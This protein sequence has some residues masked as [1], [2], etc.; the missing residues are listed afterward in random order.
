MK[1]VDRGAFALSAAL[2]AV[3]GFVDAVGFLDTGGLFVSFMSGNSTQGAVGLFD[4]GVAVA[5]VSAGIIAAFVLGVTAG[6]V[7]SM[8]A[9]RPRARV[10][11]GAAAAVAVT[12][13][14]ALAG[15]ATLWRAG[16]LAAAMGALNTLFLA[17]GR[18]R[19]AITYA[20][21]TLVSL[22]LGLASLVTGRSRTAWR[23]PLLLWASLVGGAVIGG[24]AHRLGS[25]AALALAALALVGASIVIAVRG[26]SSGVNPR[27]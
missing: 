26:G 19:V 17:E 13:G 1:D 2:S 12:A 25:P 18:A 9:S 7:V 15:D 14:L 3:A 5:L 11:A 23:R 10:V 27:R 6:A 22:G 8:R 21:G 16:L 20:T 4:G 24:V